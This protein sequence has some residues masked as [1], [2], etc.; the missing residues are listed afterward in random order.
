[1]DAREFAGI[2]FGLGGGSEGAS[3]SGGTLAEQRAAGVGST[4]IDKFRAAGTGG[5]SSCDAGS[6]SNGAGQH[7]CGPN[8]IWAAQPVAEGG[9]EA[10]RRG[11]GRERER[12]I[13]HSIRAAVQPAAQTRGR[14][15]APRIFGG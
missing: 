4:R 6:A 9:T 8:P 13:L 5:G 12:S 11:R 15:A 1:M 3:R 2:V 10:H 7:E 14:S